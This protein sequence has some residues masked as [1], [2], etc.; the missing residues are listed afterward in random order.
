MRHFLILAASLLP[1]CVFG[2][3]GIRMKLQQA[4]QPA[5]E[6]RLSEPAIVAVTTRPEKWGFFQ[7]PSLA[8][9]TDGTVAA[10]WVIH[11]L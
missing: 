6:V 2:E 7:F 5:L 8:R 1:F 9:W 4:G 11:D 10:S 3:P